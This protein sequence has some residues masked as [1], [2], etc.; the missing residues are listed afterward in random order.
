LTTKLAAAEAALQE[1]ADA[2]GALRE[3]AAIGSSR[4]TP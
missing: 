4:V 1:A 2:L 3:L